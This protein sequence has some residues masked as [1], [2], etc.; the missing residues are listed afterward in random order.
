MHENEYRLVFEKTGRLKF[1]SHL[2]LLRT[3]QRV[4]TRAG[5]PIAYSSGFNPH[6][7]MVFPLP[8]SIGMESICEICDL[9]LTV[10]IDCDKAKEAISA[11]L[12]ECMA[13]RGFYPAE[14]PL[15]EIAYAEYR[16]AIDYG[17]FSEK[18]SGILQTLFSA[19]AV[20]LKKTKSGEKETDISPQIRRVRSELSEG[21]V[22]AS[23]ICE[24][25]AAGYL[26]P[27]YA[28]M[29]LSDAVGSEP[30]EVRMVR[31]RIFDAQGKSFH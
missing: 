3:M 27:T 4:F 6:P 8:L 17:D 5:L 18:A 1:I 19:P 12:P 15:S 24:S 10:P 9:R 16:M 28:I 2:D 11:E 22:K 13:A 14:R 29:A 31:T 7:L 26:N 21:K 23:L 30:E 25:S 20:V